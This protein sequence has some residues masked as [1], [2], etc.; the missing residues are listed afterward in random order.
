MTP[1]TAKRKGAETEEAFCQWL[2]THGAP[3]AE[4]R[5]LKGRADQGDVAGW[6]QVCVEVKS[7]ASI[8]I[9]GWLAEL[10]R[11]QRNAAAAYGFVAVRPKGRPRVDDWFAVL[12]LP[13]LVELIQLVQDAR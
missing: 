10:K 3:H 11:E 12:P 5:H 13:A 1:G 9:A 7:G 2:K 8:D 6:P 4:R